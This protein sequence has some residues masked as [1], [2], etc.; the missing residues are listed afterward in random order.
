MAFDK[1][2]FDAYTIDVSNLLLLKLFLYLIIFSSIKLDPLYI[3]VYH[4]FLL[5]Q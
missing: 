3:E 1:N 4:I 2:A 5:I